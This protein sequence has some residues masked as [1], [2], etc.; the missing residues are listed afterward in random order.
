MQIEH[1]AVESLIPY[2]RNSR[3][4]SD[5]QV[6]QIAASIKEF[7]WT[8]PILVDGDNGIIAGHGRLLA[9][10]KL[11]MTHVPVIQLAGMTDTQK[12]AYIIADNKLALNAGWDD[13][14]LKLELGELDLE[15]FDLELTGFTQE[16]IDALNPEQIPEGL[17]DEDS[18]PDPPADP[19]TRLGDVWLLGKHRIMCGDSTDGGSVALLMNGAK[20]DLC[21]TSPPYGNQRDYT[22]GGISDWDKLMQGVFACIPMSDTGQVL[23]NLGLIHRDNEW[24]PYWDGWIEWMRSQGWKRFGWYVWDQ[25]FGLPGNWNGRLAPSHEFIWHFNKKSQEPNKFVSKKPENIKKRKK[26]TSTMRGKDGE[27]VAFTSPESSAQ[28]NKIPDSVIRINRMHGGHGIDHPAIFPVDL[29]VFAM[30][31]WP[32]DCYEPFSGSGTTIIAAE[33]T[34]RICYAMELSPNYV[35]VAVRRW[36]QF[37]GKQATL[38]ATGQT[39]DDIAKDKS[40]AIETENADG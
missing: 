30:Q 27:C 32:G 23:V 28:P 37:T 15:G 10:R 18:V 26:G 7:G 14:L 3:T 4:H 40:L 38:E 8:N 9:A 22:T 31:S 20:A 33:K 6:A 21:F 1:V 11:G 36:Q 12:R 25:G 29:P 35:D 39:F 13:E 24:L 19:V 5:E 16:E 34:G 2:A 17:T